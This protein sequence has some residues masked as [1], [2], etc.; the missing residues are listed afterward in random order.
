MASS[1]VRTKCANIGTQYREKTRSNYCPSSQ[2][3]WR[4]LRNILSRDSK[5]S[6]LTLAGYSCGA[7]FSPSSIFGAGL[8][9]AWA[10]SRITRNSLCTDWLGLVLAWAN[11]LEHVAPKIKISSAE[12]VVRKFASNDWKDKKTLWYPAKFIKHHENRANGPYE[13][14]FEWSA[15]LDDTLYNTEFSGVPDLRRI[16]HR[17]REFLK[18]IQYVKLSDKQSLSRFTGSKC[19]NWV[20][21]SSEWMVA[22]GLAL[23]PELE[24]VLAPANIRLM[25]HKSLAHLHHEERLARVTRIGSALL[26]FLVVQH[27]LKEPLNLNGNLVNDLWD[28]SVVTCGGDGKAALQAMYGAVNDG[29]LPGANHSQQMSWFFDRHT[30]FDSH[31]RPPL[32]RRLRNS[33]FAS[34]EAILVTVSTVSKRK[35][36]E[37]LEGSKGPKRSKLEEPKKVKAQQKTK[38]SEAQTGCRRGIMRILPSRKCAS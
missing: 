37:Q 34:T 3:L 2:R 8:P 31:W 15:C 14:E 23:T 38:N 20:Q 26:H 4:T 22:L 27:E 35:A 29:V 30:V 7:E 17:G 16:Y 36:E 11:W 33:Q 9:L 18:A 6:I 19:I 5:A 24:A 12:L 25:Q 1:N 10:V 32:Y 28:N 21:K 13:Y